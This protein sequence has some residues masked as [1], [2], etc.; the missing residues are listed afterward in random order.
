MVSTH[1]TLV[2]SN[3]DRVSTYKTS[4]VPNE[5]MVSTHTPPPCRMR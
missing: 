5:V 2:V 3:E 4:I 1:K